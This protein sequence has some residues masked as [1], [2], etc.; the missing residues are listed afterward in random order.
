MSSYWVEIKITEPDG[1]VH[2]QAFSARAQH[3]EQMMTVMVDKKGLLMYYV[4]RCREK[5]LN[6]ITKIPGMDQ[7]KL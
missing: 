3:A 2:S 5:I 7:E 6:H 4:D 1:T